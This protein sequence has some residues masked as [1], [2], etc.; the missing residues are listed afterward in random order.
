VR[1]FGDATEERLHRFFTDLGAVE[2]L[3]LAALLG[4]V[5]GFRLVAPSV[6][7]VERL[8]AAPA[9]ALGGFARVPTMIALTVVVSLA[10]ALRMVLDRGSTV[11]RVFGDELIYSG[12]GKSLALHAKPLV[13]GD[14][15]IGH[16]LFYPLFVSPAYK[17]AADGAHAFTDIKVAN[18]IAMALTAVPAYYLARRVL[19]HGWSLGVA[20]LTVAVP[21]MAY[22]ALVMTESLFYVAFTTFA[23]LFVRMLESPTWRRQLAVLAALGVL[24]GVR[25][26]ALALLGS[27]LAAIVL[28]G[29]LT[30]SVRRAL[31]AYALT[32]L[33][34]GAAGA[35]V[36]V[37]DAAGLPVP[38]SGYNVLV[39]PDYN[40]FALA[41]W[42][43]W[44]LAAYELAIGVVALAALP[45]ALVG[46]LRRSAS[47]AERAL[48]LVTLT[49]FAGVLASV[50]VLSASPYGLGHTHERS[51]FYVTPLV[52]ACFFHWLVNGLER[53]RELAVAAALAAIAVPATLSEEVVIRT[54]NQIDV[55]SMSPFVNLH[56]LAPSVPVQPWML[57]VA[58]AGV[59]AFL[60]ARRPLIPLLSVLI[61]FF[62]ILA[63]NDN[64]SIYSASQT[65]ELTWVDRA[66]DGRG[67]ATLVH[68]GITPDPSAWCSNAVKI[69][70]QDLVVLTEFFNTRVDRVVH[71]YGPIERDGLASPKLNVGEDGT[72]YEGL[73]PLRPR[74][75][76]IDS[77]LPLKGRRVA[78]LDQST[79][80]PYTNEGASLSLWRIDPPLRFAPRHAALPS[81]PDGR[82]DC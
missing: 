32:F 45:L 33:F 43:S 76:V 63:A 8:L 4:I 3:E 59:A 51:L 39:S 64:K 36:V 53:P 29:L 24:V 35:V 75:A 74:Y 49:T 69:A 54:S 50:V 66:L 37:V 18:S 65:R 41:K 46:L 31:D 6:P 17:W 5:V 44:N 2:V 40:P 78:R 13:R 19:T 62:A 79:V 7:L 56:D 60:L 1:L 73:E 15:D 28:G 38:A 70:Q 14:L 12:I 30:G 47:E 25:P 55:P 22:T 52:L 57:A 16:S 21:W 27:V 61:G 71:V 72:L 68:V 9:R 81:R 23:L 48:G 20:A 10:A 77:R 11:P 80:Q 34:V 58:V 26:Q 82:E 67:T 42:T